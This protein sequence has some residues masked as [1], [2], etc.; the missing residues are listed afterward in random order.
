MNATANNWKFTAA[1][2][3]A[4]NAAFD[5]IASMLDAWNHR[6]PHRLRL[7]LKHERR[8]RSCVAVAKALLVKGFA[9]GMSIDPPASTLAGYSDGIAV[10]V[11]IGADYGRRRRSQAVGVYDPTPADRERLP[12]LLAAAKAAH[13]AY[14]ERGLSV[15]ARS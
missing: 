6:D 13:D 9:E 5:E 7:A 11:M 8:E 1:E 14:M 3:R 4:V 12:R 10:S 15:A 2:R